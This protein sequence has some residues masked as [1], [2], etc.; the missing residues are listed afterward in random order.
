[1]AATGKKIEV[2]L[3]DDSAFIRALLAGVFAESG[4]IDV[5]GAAA[6]GRDALAKIGELRPQVVLLDVR[7][8][9][10]DGLQ[11]LNIIRRR[12]PGVAVL[13]HSGLARFD[14]GLVARAMEAGAAGFIQ[15]PGSQG[16]GPRS[17]KCAEYIEKIRAAA[18]GAARAAGAKPAAGPAEG[19]A[20]GDAG[21][22]PAAG[23]AETRVAGAKPAVARG[24]PAKGPVVAQGTAGAAEA[25]GPAEA[26]VAGAAGPTEGP[27]V[28]AERPGAAG[29]R[30]FAIGASTG[31]P[32]AL[33]TLLGGLGGAFGAALLIVQHMPEGFTGPLAERLDAVS[34][35]SVKEAEDGEPV[36]GGCAYVAPGGRH[37]L[38][39]AA[40]G[41]GLAVR[42]ERSPPVGGQIPSFGALLSS[43]G[44]A[45]A[46]ELAAVFMT[47]MGDDGAAAAKRLKELDG[48]LLVVAQD[49]ATSA[50]YGMP[51]AAVRAGIVDAVV[52]LEGMARLM[53]AAAEGGRPDWLRRGPAGAAQSG[54]SRRA[55]ERG[56][57]ASRP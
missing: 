45:R 51:G 41:G 32:G 46:G 26:Q 39:S 18:Q 11:C 33:Q 23:S 15:K 7:M 4:A 35:L 27:A 13:M 22:K 44:G 8:P 40:P 30:Y 20:A 52:P 6:D 55:D 36:L 9:V 3:V 10:M 21:A 2:L 16:I 38:V 29:I 12:H 1:M 49:E 48:S 56:A 24:A 17:G 57:G 19:P 34:A 14:A 47:G 42:L 28:G 53:R 5:V 31:G 25:A 43:F 54:V 50:V 37:M